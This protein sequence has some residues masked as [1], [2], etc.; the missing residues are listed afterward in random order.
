MFHKQLDRGCFCRPTILTRLLT[1]VYLLCLATWQKLKKWL[2]IHT[3]RRLCLLKYFNLKV[4]HEDLK[5]ETESMAT[6]ELFDFQTYSD[7]YSMLPL[8]IRLHLFINL[9][10]RINRWSG[11]LVWLFNDKEVC[12]LSGLLRYLWNSRLLPIKTI[13][14]AC[15]PLV[16]DRATQVLIKEYTSLQTLHVECS[17]GHSAA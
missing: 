3:E 12:L 4:I 15:Y 17:C 9:P 10:S 11:R 1:S 16:C 5:S 14:M 13:I 7:K 2:L 6:E 8:I